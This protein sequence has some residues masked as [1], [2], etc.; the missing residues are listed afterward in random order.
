MNFHVGQK[1]ICVNDEDGDF[2]TKYGGGYSNG[3]R[4]NAIY[5]VSRIIEERF[6][7]VAGIKG[8]WFADRFRPITDISELVKLTKVRELE[9][10]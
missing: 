9:D 5:T 3:L 2:R 10:A 7:H 4:K 6:I 1:V 8:G